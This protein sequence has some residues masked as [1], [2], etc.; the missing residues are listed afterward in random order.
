MRGANIIPEGESVTQVYDGFWLPKGLRAKLITP[1]TTWKVEYRQGGME[2]G[3]GDPGVVGARWPELS[4]SQWEIL[5][6]YL[7]EQREVI[8]M[9]FLSRMQKAIS[10]LSL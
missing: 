5:F 6:Q 9:D 1:D 4:H 10:S 8:S 7:E 2:A 3:E